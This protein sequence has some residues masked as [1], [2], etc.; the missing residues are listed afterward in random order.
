MS[1][2][3]QRLARGD[4]AREVLENEEFN[5]AFEAIQQEIIEQW[6]SAPARDADGR[7]KL[8]TMLKLSD[9]LKAALTSTLET[10]KLAKA[11]LQHKQS[12]GDR[13]RS[14]IGSD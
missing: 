7:E 10:G 9:K 5:S 6:K 8:W 1:T 4:R 11:E 13:A 14:W 2:L 3:E 12:I